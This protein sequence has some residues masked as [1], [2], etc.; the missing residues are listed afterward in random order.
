[1]MKTGEIIEEQKNV[2]Q[3]KLQPCCFKPKTGFFRD[4]FCH[5]AN[6]DQGMHTVCIEVTKE[7]LEFSKSRG[8]DLST[9]RKEFNF[10]GLNPGDKWCLCATRW[11]EAL[12]AGQ[13]PQVVLSATHEK[14]LTIVSLEELKKHAIDLV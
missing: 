7:F 5:T 14:T 8:N 1:M 10:A 9:P 13:A 3:E 6:I 2:L 11:K 12:D 4:G